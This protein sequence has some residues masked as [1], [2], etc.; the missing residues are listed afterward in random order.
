MICPDHGKVKATLQPIPNLHNNLHGFK[1]PCCP[2]CGLECSCPNHQTT[3]PHSK[4]DTGGGPPSY[5][6]C[7]QCEEI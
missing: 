4:S 1:I 5:D 3:C 7:I 6:Y 2:L